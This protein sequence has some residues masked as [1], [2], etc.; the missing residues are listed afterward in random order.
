MKYS[1]CH[2]TGAFI[3]VESLTNNTVAAGMIIEGEAAP[4]FTESQRPPTFAADLGRVDTRVATHE[5]EVDDQK[6][7]VEDDERAETRGDGGRRHAG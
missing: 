5:D 7:D 2:A 6:R 4:P 1:Q 3:L